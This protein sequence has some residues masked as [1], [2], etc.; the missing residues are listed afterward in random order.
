MLSKDE[1]SEDAQ[2]TE[3]NTADVEMADVL[4]YNEITLSGTEYA[5]LHS[6]ALTW[7]ANTR[8][9]L[10]VKT[11]SNGISY[12]YVLDSKAMLHV[13]SREKT[14]KFEKSP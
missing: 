6:E 3:E 14:K 1:K 8:N 9:K 7:G 11:L 2:K 13:Y 4:W 10:T 12:L 5:R